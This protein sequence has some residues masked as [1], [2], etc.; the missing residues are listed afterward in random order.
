MI[1]VN[2]QW[3]L[4]SSA[5]LQQS[6]INWTGRDF[7]QIAQNSTP[8]NLTCTLE[9]LGWNK[10]IEPGVGRSGPATILTDPVSG[11]KVRIHATP[12]QGTPYFR[13]QK[14]GGG[15]LDTNG[16]FPSNATRQEVRNLTHFYF[17]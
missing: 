12:T 6:N 10:V 5:P 4:V 3:V 7:S 17:E 11:T 15:Y 14:A 8:D 1:N 13:V 16:L 9:N 2:G